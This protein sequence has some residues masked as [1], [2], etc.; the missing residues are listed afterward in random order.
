[1]APEACAG[2]WADGLAVMRDKVFLEQQQ[3]T[4]SVER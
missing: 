4:A 2:E 3:T 1:V